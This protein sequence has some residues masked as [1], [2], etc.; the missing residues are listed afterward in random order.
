MRVRTKIAHVV[1]RIASGGV[2]SVL[3]S[4][5]RISAGSGYELT[6]IYG[7]ESKLPE[8]YKLFIRKNNIR[9]IHIPYLKRE[10]DPVNDFLA[11]W[12]LAYIFRR[13]KFD[14]IHCHTSK[15]G[16]LGRLA[17]GLFSDATV[18]YMPHG[19][20][21]YGYF[22]KLKTSLFI[23]LEKIAARFTDKIITLSGNESA[24]FLRRGIGK[25]NQFA[26][27]HNGIDTGYFSRAIGKKSKKREL[28]IERRSP[29]VTVIA[30]LEPVKGH[31]ILIEAYGRVAELYPGSVCLLAGDGTLKAGLKKMVKQLHLQDYFIFLGE[32]NDISEILQISDL[33]VL[34]SLNEGLGL[35]LIEALSA[36]KPVVA[37]NVG[38]VAEIIINN[39]NG[40]LVPAGNPE[41]L[42][43]AINTI[44]GNPALARKF[45][46]FGKIWAKK[47]FSEEKMRLSWLNIYNKHRNH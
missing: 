10:I 14:I 15:A 43:A 20:I 9:T 6:L 33:I 12:K 26:V 19:H 35:A 4:L 36:G 23:F 3:F 31:G 1:T 44:L 29:V 32:R 8:E 42:S 21:F 18:F 22:G 30:R 16:F 24:E 38:G 7:G 34:P 39:K 45:G 2:S 28:K 13:E 46:N 5:M 17:A 40:L 11:F 27:V 37:S 25:K 47:H 41:K